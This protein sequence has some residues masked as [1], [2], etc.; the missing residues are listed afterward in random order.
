MQKPKAM[1][2]RLDF[3]ATYLGP[4]KGKKKHILCCDEP[5]MMQV[6]IG[7]QN[8]ALKFTSSGK[9]ETKIDIVKS[10]SEES[11]KISVID[12]GVGIAAKDHEKLFKLFG[13]VKD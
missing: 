11:L 9:V 2:K 3:F 1:A 8:N 7:L 13:F 5:R 12:T 6:L 10:G 4:L